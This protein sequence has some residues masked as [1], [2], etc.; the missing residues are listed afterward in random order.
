[1]DEQTAP[2]LDSVGL[3]GEEEAPLLEQETTRVSQDLGDTLTKSDYNN[4]WKRQ[5][6]G[7]SDSESGTEMTEMLRQPRCYFRGPPCAF[8]DRDDYLTS[9]YIESPEYSE[10]SD[11]EPQRSGMKRIW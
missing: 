3:E 11:E 1:M 6:N 7:D 2:A 5:L 9:G 8:M 10:D 4:G